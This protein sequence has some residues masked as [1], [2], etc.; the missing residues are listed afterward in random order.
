MM[1]VEKWSIIFNRKVTKF[2]A[3]GLFETAKREIREGTLSKH[4]LTICK[5]GA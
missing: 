3:I 4:Y 2:A 5:T 1:R